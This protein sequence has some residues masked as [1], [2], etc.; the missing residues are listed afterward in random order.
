MGMTSDATPRRSPPSIDDLAAFALD[1]VDGDERRAI[2][3][4][5]DTDPGAAATERSLRRAAGELGAAGTVAVDTPPPSALRARVLTAAHARRAPAAPGGTTPVEMHRVELSRAIALLRT[6]GPDAWAEPLD[7]PELAGWTVHDAVVHL[8]ANEALLAQALGVG[9]A[10]VPEEEQDN[11]RRTAQARVRHRGRPTTEA[12]DE[13]ESAAE[14]VDTHVSA[15][16]VEQ[17]TGPVELWGRPSTV[18]GTLYTRSFETWTHT[19]DIRRATALPE[20]AP[21][22]GTMHLLC[23]AAIG[24]VPHMLQ[25]RGVDVPG[26]V[27]RFRLEGPGADTWEIALPGGGVQPP[28]PTDPDVEI[29]VGTV[30]LCRAVSARVPAAGLPYTSRGDTDLAR[31]IIESLPALA[32]V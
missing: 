23:R 9:L 1:A 8:A 6:L 15:L 20:A 12:L 29:S 32:V 11:E 3:D 18:V 19:D 31:R 27:V 30:D 13:L 22:P 4:H 17:L 21:P 2:A 25:A 16:T 14:A 5:L 7:P 24:L 10:G 28:G 26:R